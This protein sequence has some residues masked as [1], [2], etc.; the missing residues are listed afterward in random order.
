MKTT[1]IIAGLIGLAGGI[2]ARKSQ[3]PLPASVDQ[4]S[5]VE[6]SRSSRASSNAGSDSLIS[7]SW[8][9]RGNLTSEDLL[10]L[11]HGGRLLAEMTLWSFTATPAEL[12]EHWD[13]VIASGEKDM[14]TL[15]QLMTLWVRRDPQGALEHCR[16]G[17]QEYRAYWSLARVDPQLALDTVDPKNSRL[18]SMVLRAIGQADPDYAMT[19]IEQYPD[20]NSYTVVQGISD[21]LGDSDPAAA[22]AYSALQ[23]NF[24]EDR[25]RW[26]LAKDPHAAFA[27]S[28]DHQTL[29]A[30]TVGSLVPLLMEQDPDHFASQ[31]AGLPTGKFKLDL[32]KAQAKYLASQ[33]P[34]Q[35]LAFADTHE[36]PSRLALMEAM[37]EP[38]VSE[39]PELAHDLLK[40]LLKEEEG[41]RLLGRTIYID[42]VSSLIEQ[43]PLTVLATA[44]E[45]SP[46][47]EEGLLSSGEGQAFGKWSEIDAAASEDWLRSQDAGPRRDGLLSLQLNS[48]IHQQNA[49]YEN[50]VELSDHFDDPGQRNQSLNQVL[51]LWNNREPEKLKSFIDSPQ[52]TAAQREA[53]QS[54][55]SKQ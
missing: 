20:H 55:F 45:V 44:R 17:D 43:D 38:F 23:E 42:W 4:T 36:G 11:P 1:I 12:A 30:D 22:V 2:V 21:G 32:L 35:A 3:T 50:L 49:D 9:L 41:S 8:E 18:L 16:G 15:D 7:L 26:W 29:A 53:Y 28:L 13:R 6:G 24:E 31:I 52:S 19:L 33:D 27:W 46:A 5:S 40:T 14:N 39:R 48:Q 54:N 34:E 51:Q 37:G 10:A 25:L 47:L